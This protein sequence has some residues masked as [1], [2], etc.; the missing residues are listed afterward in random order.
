MTYFVRELPNISNEKLTIFMR[1]IDDIITQSFIKSSIYV[2]L[3]GDLFNE[4][5]FFLSSIFTS[6]KSLNEFISYTMRWENFMIY[7]KNFMKILREKALLGFE[8]NSGAEFGGAVRY[9]KDVLL[10]QYVNEVNNNSIPKKLL[11]LEFITKNLDEQYTMNINST[12]FI[13]EIQ[14]NIDNYK[15]DYEFLSFY[16]CWE[17]Y[18][19]DL[20]RSIMK[21]LIIREDLI[22]EMGTL[23]EKE[24]ENYLFNI[25]K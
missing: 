17:Q 24:K 8:K 5:A 14:K 19:R 21:S 7:E 3:F 11:T 23:I 4:N 16:E 15:F 1:V 10:R 12:E 2:R 6:K 18:I 13:N 9:K 25:N 20:R 22:K